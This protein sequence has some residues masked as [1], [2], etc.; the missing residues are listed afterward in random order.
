MLTGGEIPAC[1]LVDAVSRTV[2]GVLSAPE[3]FESESLSDGTLEYPQYTRP[4]EFHG[5]RV[6]D[7]LINGERNSRGV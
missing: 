7:V 4:Y 1:I 5:V 3:C 2:E 6:P